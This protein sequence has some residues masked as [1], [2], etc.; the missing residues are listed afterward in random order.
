MP[1]KVDLDFTQDSFTTFSDN[2]YSTFEAVKALVK[3]YITEEDIANRVTPPGSSSGTTDEEEEEEFDKYAV[4]EGS[5]VVVTY[6]GKNGVDA[7]PYK[8][9]ILNYNNFSVSVEYEGLLYTLP[10]Y[11]YVVVM[12]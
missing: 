1:A 6:G 4:E 12:Q 10:A 9:I 5:I 8:S 7:D 11:G 3:G 2:A